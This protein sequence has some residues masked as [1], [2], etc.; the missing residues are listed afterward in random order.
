MCVPVQLVDNR[1]TCHCIIRVQLAGRATIY[2]LPTTWWRQ[3]AEEVNTSSKTQ[4]ETYVVLYH[5]SVTRR[6]RARGGGG[7]K[8]FRAQRPVKC[9]AG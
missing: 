6:G 8:F 4:S 5:M 7:V 2:N 3:H 9:P 1:A